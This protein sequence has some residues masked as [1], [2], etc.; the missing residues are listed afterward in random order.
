[1]QIVSTQCG[2]QLNGLATLYVSF[3]QT[4]VNSFLRPTSLTLTPDVLYRHGVARGLALLISKLQV[5][6]DGLPRLFETVHM[7]SEYESSIW[8]SK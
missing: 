6:Y 3:M 7:L 2:L 5:N 4:L 1:M 8:P